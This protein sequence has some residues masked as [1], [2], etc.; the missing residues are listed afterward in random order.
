MPE[1]P[2]IEAL[3]PVLAQIARDRPDILSAEEFRDI[4]IDMG[5]PL[6]KAEPETDE[7]T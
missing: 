2:E 4:L 6:K 5:L 1:K 3:L 7:Q